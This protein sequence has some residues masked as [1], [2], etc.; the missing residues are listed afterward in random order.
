MILSPAPTRSP[1]RRL[2]VLQCEPNSNST[3]ASSVPVFPLV[4]RSKLAPIWSGKEPGLFPALKRACGLS[5]GREVPSGP[6]ENWLRINRRCRDISSQLSDDFRRCLI[7][8]A[9]LC[10][11][12]SSSLFLLSLE[13]SDTKVCMSLHYEPALEFQRVDLRIVC[14]P[15]PGTLSFSSLAVSPSGCGHAGEA[16]GLC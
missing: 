2:D 14:Q 4:D 11:T 7:K 3:L 16:S 6:P 10:R 1:H 15:A 8:L 9:D 13:S 5:S 12:L